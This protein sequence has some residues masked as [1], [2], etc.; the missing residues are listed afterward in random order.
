MT[1]KLT[2]SDCRRAGYCV[3]G[4]RRAARRFEID[5]RSF[6]REGVPLERA[7][8]IEDRNMQKAVQAARDRIESERERNGQE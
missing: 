7:A 2:I 3:S 8:K 6:L 4:C 5:F 1:E